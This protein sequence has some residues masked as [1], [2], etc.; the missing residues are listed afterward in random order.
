MEYNFLSKL[1]ENNCSI[2]QIAEETNTSSGTV[3]YWLRKYDLKT[4][5]YLTQTNWTKESIEN[6]IKSATSKSDILRNLNIKIN[7]GNF[8]T[9]DK[10]CSRYNI[11]ISLKKFDH[12]AHSKIHGFQKKLSNE[13]IFCL[14]S[15]TDDTKTIKKRAIEEGFLKNQCY[16]CGLPPIWN[17]KKLKLQLDHINGN[18][19]DNQ[20]ENLRILCPNCHSQTETFCS[21][22]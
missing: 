11:D 21:K 20:I 8:Q 17:G 1:V 4:N 19:K 22:K 12:K 15:K 10:Y 2:N 14:N 16:E 6:A 9:L 18:R 7:S 5:G 13:E 3:R